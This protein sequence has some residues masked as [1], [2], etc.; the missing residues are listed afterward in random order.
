MN[1]P[2][3]PCNFLIDCGE[4]LRCGCPEDDELHDPLGPH[5]HHVYDPTP[6]IPEDI[7]AG[8]GVGGVME[9]PFGNV[10][11]GD[12]DCSASTHIHGCFADYGDCDSPNEHRRL[13][14]SK[15][16]ASEEPT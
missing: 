4:L 14:D 15:G 6:L 7:P 16:T 10:C 5:G 3:A 12:F 9:P 13:S 2:Q 1:D 11:V 8:S